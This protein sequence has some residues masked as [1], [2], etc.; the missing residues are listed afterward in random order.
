MRY[1]PALLE[2]TRDEIIKFLR[3]IEDMQ[4]G[5]EDDYAC[6]KMT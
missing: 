4:G 2:S 3:V 5:D 1:D 6:K